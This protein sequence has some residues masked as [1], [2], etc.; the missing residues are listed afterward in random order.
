[1]KR[2]GGMLAL[3]LLLAEAR[4]ETEV[5]SGTGAERESDPCKLVSQNMSLTMLGETDY[6]LAESREGERVTRLYLSLCHP[7]QG[8][9]S[10]VAE[11]CRPGAQ[12]CLTAVQNGTE[13]KLWP[14]AGASS[15]AGLH[16]EGQVRYST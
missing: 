11:L 7:L 9:P 1:M 3:L 15:V 8:L 10:T 6:Y 14:D 12:A 2:M 5:G 4:A 13:Q 16:L